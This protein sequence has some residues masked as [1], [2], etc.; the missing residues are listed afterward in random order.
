MVRSRAF[1]LAGRSLLARQSS[2]AARRAIL[3]VALTEGVGA[4]GPSYIFNPSFRSNLD[5]AAANLDS[6][7]LRPKPF[8]SDFVLSHQLASEFST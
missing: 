7:A 4:L 3:P 5:S 1:G 6:K 8:R 2:V